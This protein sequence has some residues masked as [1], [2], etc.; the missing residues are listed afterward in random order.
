[1]AYTSPRQIWETMMYDA[2]HGIS[3]SSTALGSMSEALRELCEKDA[4]GIERIVRD[5]IV[6]Y[7]ESYP[8][9]PNDDTERELRERAEKANAWLEAHG[10]AKEPLDWSK[11]ELPCL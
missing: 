4:L 2:S 7:V 1:M 3:W 11:E 9:A 5:A 6:G 10:F 8:R